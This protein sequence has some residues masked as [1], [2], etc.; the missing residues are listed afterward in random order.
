M[1]NRD[2]TLRLLVKVE[3]TEL[4][5]SIAHLIITCKFFLY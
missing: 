1:T 3:I 2:M 4:R 5:Y